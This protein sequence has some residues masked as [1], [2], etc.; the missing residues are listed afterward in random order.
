VFV[1][2]PEIDHRIVPTSSCQ[3]RPVGIPLFCPVR[4]GEKSGAAGWLWV[5]PPLHPT[6]WAIIAPR[7]LMSSAY[8]IIF[9]RISHILPACPSA[10]AS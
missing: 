9:E 2:S 7:P 6:L 3:A 8:T 5:K 4:P 10:P 1:F